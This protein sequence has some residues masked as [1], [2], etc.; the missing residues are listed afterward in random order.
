MENI[1]QK[2]L[3]FRSVFPDRG[4]F[5]TKVIKANIIAFIKKENLKKSDFGFQRFGSVE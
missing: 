1:L 5:V 2:T 3:D 4:V